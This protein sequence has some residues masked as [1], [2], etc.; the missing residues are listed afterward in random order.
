MNNNTKSRFM[1]TTRKTRSA[2]AKGIKRLS[3]KPKVAAKGGGGM[4]L[5]EQSKKFYGI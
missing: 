4:S 3:I 2:E 5:A 1:L